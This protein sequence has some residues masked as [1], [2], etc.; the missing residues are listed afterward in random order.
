MKQEPAYISIKAEGI[1]PVHR[2]LLYSSSHCTYQN[3]L[4]TPL[5]KQ[6]SEGLAK[7]SHEHGVWNVVQKDRQNELI[8]MVLATG[9]QLHRS[10][11]VV[12]TP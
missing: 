2:T 8:I 3:V 12:I 4:H 5:L 11:G 1:T 10:V 9:L 6:S 7:Q